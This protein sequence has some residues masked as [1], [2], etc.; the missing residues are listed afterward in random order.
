MANE[1][2]QFVQIYNKHGRRFPQNKEE[3]ERLMTFSH[4]IALITGTVRLIMSGNAL[5]TK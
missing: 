3:Q 4:L 5:Y 1:T 2:E